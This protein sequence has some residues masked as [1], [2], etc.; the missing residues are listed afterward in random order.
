MT[1]IFSAVEFIHQHGVVH[2]DLKPEVLIY[3]TN[4]EYTN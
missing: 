4:R 3:N 1:S 2:R